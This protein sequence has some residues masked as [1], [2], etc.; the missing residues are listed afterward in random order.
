M[1]LFIDSS[2]GHLRAAQDLLRSYE[3]F[4]GEIRSFTS[5]QDALN[6]LRRVKTSEEHEV[7]AATADLIFM[8][9]SF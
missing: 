9:Y 4:K 7:L 2:E 6:L 1:V 3:D 8:T 5:G